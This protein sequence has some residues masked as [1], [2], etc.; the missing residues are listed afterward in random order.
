MLRSILLAAFLD[1]MLLTLAG[2][3]QVWVKPGASHSD[4]SI[5]K[6]ACLQE[7]QQN[8]SSAVVNPYG[9]AAQSGSVTN[10]Y[11]FNSCMNAKGWALQNAN[12][13][14]EPSVTETDYT[15]VDGLQHKGVS[16]ADAMKR[17]T[18]D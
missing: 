17:C 12:S 9:G 14:A 3:A 7:S 2:C 1:A 16:H 6:Y 10:V 5:D 15:C 18:F 11:L 13:A 8:Q 4:F